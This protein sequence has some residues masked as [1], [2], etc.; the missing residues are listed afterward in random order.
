MY[1]RIKLIVNVKKSV[2]IYSMIVR[3]PEE[4][5]KNKIGGEK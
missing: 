1:N 4:R 3:R 2:S 5:V